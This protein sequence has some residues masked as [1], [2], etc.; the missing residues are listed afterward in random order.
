[1]AESIEEGI[2]KQ[3]SNIRDVKAYIKNDKLACDIYVEGEIDAEKV[4]SEYNKDVPRYEQVTD[5]RV[6][7]DSID[8]RLKQ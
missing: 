3:D 8:I 1:M 5:Y 6:I 2:K 7:K 4:V